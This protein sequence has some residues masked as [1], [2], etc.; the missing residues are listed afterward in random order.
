MI[1]LNKCNGSC[2]TFNSSSK[3]SVPNK[4]QSTN[5]ILFNI[6]TKINEVKTLIMHILCG[7]KCKFDSTTCNSNRKWNNETSQCKCKNY[8][9]FKK[10][11]S[12]NTRKCICKNGKYFK[13]ITDKS[14][15]YM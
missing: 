4:T 12:W 8:H 3:V 5:V 10:S 9:K 14:V 15:I 11:Y 7:C 13:S 2:N 6:I 1:S